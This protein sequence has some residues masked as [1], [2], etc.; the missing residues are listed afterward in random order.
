VALQACAAL[1]MLA[2]A[3]AC[4]AA[5]AAALA[6]AAGSGG[7]AAAAAARGSGGAR[8]PLAAV[9]LDGFMGGRHALAG[10]MAAAE[11][12][13]QLL[14]AVSL[15]AE[16]AAGRGGAA[17]GAAA[18]AGVAA[19]ARWRGVGPLCTFVARL[20][21]SAELADDDVVAAALAGWLPPFWD[22]LT[23]SIDQLAASSP[24]EPGAA[25]AAGD[26]AAA[27]AAPAADLLAFA[28]AVM[29]VLP[30][31]FLFNSHL[32]AQQRQLAAWGDGGG[33]CGGAPAAPGAR[34]VP[35]DL[36]WLAGLLS[37][38][39]AVSRGGSAAL[40]V[41]W[42]ECIQTVLAVARGLV[43]EQLPLPKVGGAPG[44]PA[45]GKQSRLKP[46]GVPAPA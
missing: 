25:G 8:E 2:P 41:A 28:P 38:A 17:P 32:S 4:R 42:M 34:L 23:A 9:D 10:L 46:D 13:V 36:S 12:A 19:G 1:A 16:A 43:G 39:R 45:D 3:P 21:T 44:G 30:A 29:G 20:L 33:G 27:A 11:A 7:G 31:A 24:L 18:A 40:L 6:A 15:A 14:Q 37:C 22:T 5:A 35:E 26:R